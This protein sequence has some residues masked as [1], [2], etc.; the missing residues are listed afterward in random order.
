M[1][2]N[3]CYFIDNNSTL[4]GLWLRTST[5]PHLPSNLNQNLQHHLGSMSY[6][7]ACHIDNIGNRQGGPWGWYHNIYGGNSTFSMSQNIP[8]T[9][10]Q[11]CGKDISPQDVNSYGYVGS[12]SSLYLTTIDNTE[13]GFSYP[14][15]SAHG[16]SSASSSADILEVYGHGATTGTLP[17][18]NNTQF[19]NTNSPIFDGSCYI[20]TTGTVFSRPKD[21]WPTFYM[22]WFVNGGTVGS[23]MLNLSMKKDPQLVI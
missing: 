8:H 12:Y 15:D 20:S 18:D 21:L 10:Y 7:D 4:R 13:S 23:G 3:T 5:I 6:W 16:L 19:K 2:G 14:L 1:I 17:G 22:V 11:A 9:W